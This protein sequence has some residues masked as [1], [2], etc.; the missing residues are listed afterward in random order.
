MAKEIAIENP[1]V[2]RAERAGYF[3]RKAGWV[4]RRSAPDRVFARKDRGT[5]WIEFK[6]PGEM[7]TKLQAEEHAKMRAAGMEVHVCDS[8]DDA[9]RILWLRGPGSNQ[10]DDYEDLV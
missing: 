2:V 3:V 6:R 9:M 5:V 8:I 7:P 1:V 10:P 4:G